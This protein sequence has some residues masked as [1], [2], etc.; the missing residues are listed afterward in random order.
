MEGPRCENATPISKSIKFNGWKSLVKNPRDLRRLR[1]GL[2]KNLQKIKKSKC[3]KGASHRL[4]LPAPDLRE[5]SPSAPCSF[6]V[7]F[8]APGCQDFDVEKNQKCRRGPRFSPSVAHRRGLDQPSPL[9]ISR[10]LRRVR[11][12]SIFCPSAG[13]P[14]GQKSCKSE[15]G[16][17]NFRRLRLTHRWPTTPENRSDGRGKSSLSTNWGFLCQRFWFFGRKTRAAGFFFSTVPIG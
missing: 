10:R 7:G 9:R 16:V 14:R 15:G 6:F 3:R 5:F 1:R 12:F 13:G 17:I 8:V 4:P 11:V 2:V